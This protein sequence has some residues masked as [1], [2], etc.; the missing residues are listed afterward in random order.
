MY[1]NVC[2]NAQNNPSPL[3]SPIPLNVILT[4][5]QA[6]VKIREVKKED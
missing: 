3:I 5:K 2:G 4:F 6:S 1:T